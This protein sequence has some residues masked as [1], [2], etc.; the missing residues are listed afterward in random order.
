M[1][2][3]AGADTFIF[4]PSD[5]TTKSPDTI[6]DFSSRQGDKIV[7]S[8]LD[9]NSRTAS[10]DKFAFVGSQGFTGVAGQLRYDVKNGGAT[11]YGDTNGDGRADFTI[12]LLNVSSLSASDFVL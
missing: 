1:T 9:A 4:R 7:L 6:T 10:D 3:G 8:L 11:V 12:V 2:G 5:V